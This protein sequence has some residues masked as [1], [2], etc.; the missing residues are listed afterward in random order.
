MLLVLA[1]SILMLSVF[2]AAFTLVLLQ[3]GVIEEANPFMRWLIEHDTQIFIN[4]KIV[5]TGACVVFMVLCSNALVA[6]RIRGRRV[7]HG[8]LAVYVLVI[9]YELLIF[10]ITGLG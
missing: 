10:R 9:L 7:M 3:A 8:V 2:D 5:I 6:G 4:L 1:L